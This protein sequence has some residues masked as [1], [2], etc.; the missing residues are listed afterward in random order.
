ML[1][2]TIVRCGLAVV[3]QQPASIAGS[4]LAIALGCGQ[5]YR[6]ILVPQPGALWARSHAIDRWIICAAGGTLLV[7]ALRLIVRS[8]NLSRTVGDYANIGDMCCVLGRFKEASSAAVAGL[9][10]DPVNRRCLRAATIASFGQGDY[11]RALEIGERWVLPSEHQVKIG[12]LCHL[13][14]QDIIARLL[15][16][17][18]ERLLTLLQLM[19]D[20]H[21]AEIETTSLIQSLVM[22]PYL[23]VQDIQRFR[24]T[25]SSAPLICATVEWEAR[26]LQSAENTLTS[27]VPATNIQQTHKELLLMRLRWAQTGSTPKE[28]DDLVCYLRVSLP[29][30]AGELCALSANV[31]WHAVISPSHSFCVAG[32][33]RLSGNVSPLK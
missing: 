20:Q 2:R 28:R 33:G 17:R 1:S 22:S 32:H 7:I 21:C 30:L 25:A 29:S 6:F 9:T 24:T 23:S 14:V 11:H 8:K 3:F 16:I 18:P 13:L 10:I 4:H 12:T 26:D 5:R 27:F 31:R 15:P 19:I